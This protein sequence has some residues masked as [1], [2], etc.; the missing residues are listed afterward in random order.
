M[1]IVRIARYRDLTYFILRDLK[2][3][4]Y[5]LAYDP[6]LESL[7]EKVVD[8]A[9]VDDTFTVR[10]AS[11]PR[12]LPLTVAEHYAANFK[13]PEDARTERRQARVAL[14]LPRL[15]IPPMTF[16][17]TLDAASD[18][19]DLIERLANFAESLLPKRS[20]VPL[21]PADALSADSPDR[22]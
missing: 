19:G 2:G 17:R 6:R 13:D 5:S 7:I 12:G 22:D 3:Q 21:T 15:E 18:E 11:G 9:Q 16:R 10:I 8:V 1:T 4:L 14:N 20:T